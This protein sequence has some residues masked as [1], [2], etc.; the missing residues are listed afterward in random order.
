MPRYD[1]VAIVLHWVIG[2]AL[3]A[4]IAFGFSLDMVAPRGTPWRALVINTHK[5]IGIVLG[6][7]IL[8]R[9][10]WRM[11]HR[12]PQ[13]PEGFTGWRP[14]AATALH[15]LLYAL[16]VA[17]PLAGYSGSNF[18]RFGIRFFGHPLPPWGPDRPEVYDVL[19]SLHVGLAWMLGI[20]IALHVAAAL[21]HALID[22][23]GLFQR[24]APAA[25]T[26]RPP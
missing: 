20:L 12:P 8:A 5:S 2:A 11:T 17:V 24:M 22:R 16:M 25:R 9:L 26:R 19:T 7:A 14:R 21:Q 23:D 4:Q 6:L 10:A 1:R 18:S 15:R 13:W 3:L